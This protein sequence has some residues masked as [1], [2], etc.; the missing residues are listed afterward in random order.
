MITLS[1]NASVITISM[2]SLIT[3]PIFQINDNGANRSTLRQYECSQSKMLNYSFAT[4]C[5]Y[6]YF[7][8]CKIYICFKS[9]NLHTKYG[10]IFSSTICISDHEFSDRINPY[11]NGL[12]AHLKVWCPCT[13][14]ILR[15]ESRITD[16]KPLNILQ[17]ATEDRTDHC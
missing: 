17:A 8:V 2:D 11:F 13:R 6:A 10:C 12:H 7:F 14:F 9:R 15:A 5:H 3:K 4:G 16:N 1:Q